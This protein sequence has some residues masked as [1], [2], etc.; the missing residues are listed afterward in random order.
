MDKFLITESERSKF[1][2]FF[3]T[4]DVSLNEN[5]NMEKELKQKVRKNSELT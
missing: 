5:K 4:S 3:F 1:F 2:H